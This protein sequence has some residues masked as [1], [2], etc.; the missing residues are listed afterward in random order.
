M[1]V[2]DWAEIKLANPGSAIR[3]ASVARHVSDCGTQSAKGMMSFKKGGRLCHL[4]KEKILS[5][6]NGVRLCHLGKVE[7]GVI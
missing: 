4:R 2:W 1:R 6:M 5:F 3:L 7:D